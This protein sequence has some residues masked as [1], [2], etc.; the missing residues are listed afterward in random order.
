MQNV[1]FKFLQVRDI[2]T[3]SEDILRLLLHLVSNNVSFSPMICHIQS[4]NQSFILTRYVEELENLFKIRTCINKIYN[5][6][7]Y[8]IILFNFKNNS[9]YIKK[10]IVMKT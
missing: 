10:N 8:V 2:I 5:N 1:Q 7:S 6:Y 3:C 4:I 9:I